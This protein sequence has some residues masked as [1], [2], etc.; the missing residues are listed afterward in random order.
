MAIGQ[1]GMVGKATVYAAIELSKK[2]WVVGIAH[3]DRDRPSIHR[4]VGGNL[5]GVVARLR[6]AAVV[7]GHVTQGLAPWAE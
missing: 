7:C 5:A 3:P 2:S 4:F 6:K 1:Q